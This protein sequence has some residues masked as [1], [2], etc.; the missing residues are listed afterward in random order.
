MS[1]FLF[2]KVSEKE[3][4]EIK[5]E[6][7][8]IMDNF[9]KKLSKIDKKIPE[10]LIER[11]DFEREEYPTAPQQSPGHPSQRNAK[12]KTQPDK[13]E[14]EDFRKRFF[15]NAPNKNKDFII[16]EKKKW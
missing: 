3:K 15:E 6:A 9:S 5:K 4:E 7:K 12:F 1:D 16:A 11:D 13:E 2:H 8:R 10:P 14:K